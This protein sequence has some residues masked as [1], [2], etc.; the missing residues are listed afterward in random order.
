METISTHISIKDHISGW[1][2]Q[3][4][5]TASARSDLGFSD[6]ISATYH[7]GLAEEIDRLFCQ[8]PYKLGFS[9]KRYQQITDFEIV[10]RAGGFDVELMRTIQLM[11]AAFNMNNK[12]TGL[13]SMARA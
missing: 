3:K 7:S 8:I 9:P 2:K 13:C 5:R 4:E 12:L 10:K 6:H 11:V 1:Q